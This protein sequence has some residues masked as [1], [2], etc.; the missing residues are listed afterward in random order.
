LQTP[1]SGNQE[2]KLPAMN[3]GTENHLV[4]LS[5]GRVNGVNVV[6]PGEGGN[7]HATD[8]LKLFANFEYKP[9]NFEL[10]DVRRAAESNRSIRY[11]NSIDSQ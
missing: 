3:R 9:M 1:Q 10:T 11:R 4:V 2:P 5:K 7:P 6:P 8:Q